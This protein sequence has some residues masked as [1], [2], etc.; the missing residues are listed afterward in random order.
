MTAGGGWSPHLSPEGKDD[1]AII[2]SPRGDPWSAPP[3]MSVPGG[4]AP[5]DPT[6]CT[7]V[8]KSVEDAREAFLR[9]RAGGG[10]MTPDWRPPELSYFDSGLP[11]L[12]QKSGF[13]SGTVDFEGVFN[14]GG[15]PDTID[16]RQLGGWAPL[17]RYCEGNEGLRQSF[18]VKEVQESGSRA[19]DFFHYDVWSIRGRCSTV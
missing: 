14:V 9:H 8:W 16:V 12:T 7:L 5:L 10:Y 19:E 4:P 1:D 3:R 11:R 17:L 6:L 13:A 18:L 15:G 2:P